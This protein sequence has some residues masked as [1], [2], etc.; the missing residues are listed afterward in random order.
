MSGGR[1]ADVTIRVEGYRELSRAFKKL[2][3]DL[4]RELPLGLREAAEPVKDLATRLADTQISNIGTVWDR[5]RIGV[6]TNAVYIAPASRRRGGSPRPN[7]SPLLLNQSMLPA[8]E[9]SEGEVVRRLDV[10]L[11][12]LFREF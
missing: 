5:M 8:V 2:D 1:V 7:L 6:T 3:S 9:R 10:L 11:E 12:H 4:K